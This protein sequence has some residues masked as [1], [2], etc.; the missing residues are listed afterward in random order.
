LARQKKRVIIVK[1]PP[2]ARRDIDRFLER[3]SKALI[4][5]IARMKL[6]GDMLKIEVYGSKTLAKAT[7]ARVRRLLRE[8]SAP[9]APSGD[10]VY[11]PQR[12][13]REAGLAIPLDV[14]VEVLKAS[15]YRASLED[16]GLKTNAP[17]DEV[18]SAAAAIAQAV[19]EAATLE[20]TRTAKKL[21]AA[22]SALRGVSLLQALDEALDAGALEED[23]EGK[24]HVVGDWREW[25]KRLARQPPGEGG[26]F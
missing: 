21:L 10:I 15:G 25:V 4:G 12:L 13:F 23:D 24:L 7:A 17:E 18:F 14:L 5:E 6:A 19:K 20:A 3:L 9:R 2:T 8:Y 1:L 11:R 16:S 26:E 22:L